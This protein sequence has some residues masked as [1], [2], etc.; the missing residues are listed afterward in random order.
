[1]STQN[2]SPYRKQFKSLRQRVCQI[3]VTCVHIISVP[4]LRCIRRQGPNRFSETGTKAMSAEAQNFPESG[5][6]CAT[7]K[8][9]TVGLATLKC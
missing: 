6:S 4:L 1:M 9:E 2:A 7:L 5:V 8:V 3:Q